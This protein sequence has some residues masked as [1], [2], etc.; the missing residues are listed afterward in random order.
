[1]DLLP[2]GPGAT[3]LAAREQM[4]MTVTPSAVLL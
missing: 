4:G 2:N 1:M 3:E